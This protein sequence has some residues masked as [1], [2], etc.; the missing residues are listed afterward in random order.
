MALAELLKKAV[1]LEHWGNLPAT[2]WMLAATVVA[3]LYVGL[4]LTSD[5]TGINLDALYELAPV[6]LTGWLVLLASWWVTRRAAPGWAI[7]L[8]RAGCVVYV[9]PVIGLAVMVAV[10]V[11]VAVALVAGMVRGEGRDAS[12]QTNQFARC[13]SALSTNRS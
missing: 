5:A 10:S 12:P 1:P 8:H 11:A 4:P 7:H 9:L 2:G 6:L 13:T 3:V